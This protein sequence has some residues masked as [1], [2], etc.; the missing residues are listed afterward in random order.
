[1]PVLVHASNNWML[2]SESD[3]ASSFYTSHLQGS[4]SNTLRVVPPD[5]AAVNTT[6]PFE[7]P[8][9]LAMIGGLDTIV[10]STLVEN[11]SAPSKIAD[12]SWIKPGRSGWSWHAGGNQSDY[13]T[14]VQFVDAAA[15]MGWEYYLID[16]GWQASW[17][18]RWWLTRRA[19]ASAS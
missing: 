16:E 1:M 7:S 17:C 3:V 11:L 4:T 10:A 12:T 19:R 2:I 15:A 6:G 9:R 14:H 8:W 18:P 5:A 13:D